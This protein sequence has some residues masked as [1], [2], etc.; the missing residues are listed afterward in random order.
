MAAR[1]IVACNLILEYTLSVA[2][3]ARAATAYGATLVGLPPQSVL[4]RIGPLS[5]DVCAVVL[6]AALGTLLA[7]GT[8]QSAAFN[9]GAHW[10]GSFPGSLPQA[11]ARDMSLGAV[12]LLR[13]AYVA[14]HFTEQTV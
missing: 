3:C 11:P 6:I 12:L 1:R 7:L 4:V 2:V 9:A 13:R 5:M 14:C 8:K 10:H